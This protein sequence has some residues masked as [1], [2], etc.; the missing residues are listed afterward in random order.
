MGNKKMDTI[1]SPKEINELNQKTDQRDLENFFFEALLK[2]G[3]TEEGAK[4]IAKN[5]TKE[6]TD[7][8]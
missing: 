1:F 8:L 4:K 3:E 7:S 5:W 6:M 2:N